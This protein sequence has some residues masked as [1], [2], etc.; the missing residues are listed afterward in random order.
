MASPSIT[1]VQVLGEEW[2]G[3]SAG[4]GAEV[5]VFPHAAAVAA[6][7]LDAAIKMNQVTAQALWEISRILIIDR[8]E[9]PV[10][11]QNSGVYAH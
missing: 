4:A 1:Q 6:D 8:G 3:H 11:D 7:V 10:N 5:V 9:T 2:V